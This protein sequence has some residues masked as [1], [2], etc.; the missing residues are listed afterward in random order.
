MNEILEQ[1]EG[2]FFMKLHKKV[3]KKKKGESRRSCFNPHLAIITFTN[4]S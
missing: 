4:S 1:S 3:V 2:T